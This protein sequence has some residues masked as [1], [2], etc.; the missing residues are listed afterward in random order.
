MSLSI[1]SDGC[2]SN[3]G[4]LAVPR[5]TA[6]HQ[7]HGPCSSSSVTAGLGSPY[8]LYCLCSYGCRG[9]TPPRRS[10]LHP[11]GRTR[12]C[13]RCGFECSHQHRG[14]PHAGAQG[15]H[16]SGFPGSGP[17]HR[18]Q[19]RRTWGPM[20]PSPQ[21]LG[22]VAGWSRAGCRAPTLGMASQEAPWRAQVQNTCGFVSG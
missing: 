4:C 12:L 5:G 16:T 9:S 8:S 20:P 13:C 10:T 1:Y 15:D 6:G 18:S 22:R 14:G 19:G 7:N 11:Q 3:D 2:H 21:P 17:G